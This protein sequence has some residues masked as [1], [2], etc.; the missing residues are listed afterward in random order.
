M[1]NNICRAGGQKDAL[2]VQGFFFAIQSLSPVE[3]NRGGGLFAPC[4]RMMHYVIIVITD[5]LESFQGY[6]NDSPVAKLPYPILL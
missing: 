1:R 2:Q 6:G 4:A 5:T 3:R